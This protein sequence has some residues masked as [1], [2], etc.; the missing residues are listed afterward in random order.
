[1]LHNIFHPKQMLHI[2]KAYQF[3]TKLPTSIYVQ[4]YYERKILKSIWSM[5]SW[6]FWKV[7]STYKFTI[8]TKCSIAGRDRE[9]YI[10]GTMEHHICSPPQW[11]RR[12]RQCHVT[13]ASLSGV[14]CMYSKP[15]L[16][17]QKVLLKIKT[18]LLKFDTYISWNII[19]RKTCQSIW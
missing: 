1:M 9:R 4:Q 6:C 19:C 17:E 8:E 10:S 2:P 5:L 16:W 13:C 14:Y 3:S 12:L 15:R 18:L 7:S 11:T